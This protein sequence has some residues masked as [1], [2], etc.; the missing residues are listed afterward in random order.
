MR[1]PKRHR[2]KRSPRRRPKRPSRRRRNPRPKGRR[3]VSSFHQDDCRLFHQTLRD[4]FG[5]FRRATLIFFRLPRDLYICLLLLALVAAPPLTSATNPEGAATAAPTA[6]QTPDA[7]LN[8]AYKFNEG[9]WTYVHLEGT[10]EQVGFQHGYLLAREIEDNVHVYTVTAPNA[11]KRPW[12]FFRDAGRDVLWPH[13]DAEYQAE[14][15]GIVEGLQAQGST[16]DLWDI[17][18]LNGDLEISDYYL[19]TLNKREGRPNPEAAVAPGKCSAFIATGS[20]TKD[21]KIVVG[22]S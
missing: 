7:R 6:G 5:A 19:P 10:P 11:D 14:L 15:K 16:L 20:A 2:R 8:G 12:S 17:V 3:S 1:R 22:H 9:G 4:M 18:A 21:G 13:L